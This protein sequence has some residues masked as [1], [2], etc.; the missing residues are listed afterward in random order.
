[1]K[2]KGFLLVAAAVLAAACSV[3]NY[4]RELGPAKEPSFK[5][6]EDDG[7]EISGYV[8]YRGGH[9]NIDLWDA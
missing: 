8:T 2:I 3:D 5:S 7:L 6:L 1:M 4:S 9:A